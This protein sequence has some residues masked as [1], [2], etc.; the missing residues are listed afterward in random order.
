MMAGLFCT[1]SVKLS[2]TLIILLGAVLYGV[3]TDFTTFTSET[4]GLL[5]LVSLISELG[6]RIVLRYLSGKLPVSRDFSINS[7]VCHF[8][9]ILAS[10]ALLGS[11]FGFLLWELVA[12]KTLL[13]HSD[14][15]SKVLLRLLG[16]AVFRF[17]CGIIMIVIIH[18]Y[19]FL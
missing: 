1:L 14:T 8:G 13:P 7:T 2:G 10:D 16:L 11:V 6:G 17:I 15:V 4:I 18:L 9:G 3:F 5:I 12:G 19:I